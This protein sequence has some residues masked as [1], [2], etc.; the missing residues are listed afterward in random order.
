MGESLAAG[1]LDEVAAL[2]CTRTEGWAVGLQLAC[3]S[4]RA[5]PDALALARGIS[6]TSRHIA[7]FLLDEVLGHQPEALLQMLLVLALPERFCQ[8]LYTALLQEQPRGLAQTPIA[9]IERQGLFLV[10]LDDE[11]TWY[12]YHHF[13]RDLLLFRLTE[14]I[15]SEGVALLHRRCSV[16][17]ASRGLIEE[18]VRHALQVGDQAMAARLVEESYSALLERDEGLV[19][20]APLL[21]LLP[22]P[23]IA[24]RPRLLLACA[25]DCFIRWDF[26][27]FAAMT[28]R[29][30]AQLGPTNQ[31]HIFEGA[32]LRGDIALLEGIARFWVGDFIRAGALIEEAYQHISAARAHTY[33]LTVTYLGGA[34]FHCGDGGGAITFIRGHLRWADAPTST[35]TAML[36]V[37]LNYINLLSGRLD[38]VAHDARQLSGDDPNSN[39]FYWCWGQYLLG[40]YHYERNELEAAEICFLRASGFPYNAQ[41]RVHHDSLMGLAHIAL[42]RG[43]HKRA[44]SYGHRGRVFAEERANPGLLEATAALE[45]VVALAQGDWASASW[46]VQAIDPALY[47]GHALWLVQARWCWAAV[48]IGLA[49]PESL[50]E[51]TASLARYLAEAEVA[52]NVYWQIRAGGLLALAHHAQGQHEAALA[53]LGRAV[54]L[55][56]PGGHIRSLVDCGPPIAA[57]LRQLSPGN[58]GGPNVVRVLAAFGEGAQPPPERTASLEA[59]KAAGTATPGLLSK[60]EQDILVL[61]AERLTDQE[62]AER[63]IIAITTVRTHTRRIYSKLEVTNR[64]QAISRAGELGLL[65]GYR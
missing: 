34:R 3:L 32:D 19:R 36:L 64:R 62:I 33:A 23:L 54:S 9:E 55:A 21:A 11:G 14:T 52:H 39:R 31:E 38:Q 24:S 30:M 7:D 50:A 42:V 2:L 58:S 27:A 41:E 18:A 8:E 12:R 63:L 17:F 57:L 37:G 1:S 15:G 5:A 35:A 46:H 65:E 53:A 40:R 56:A 45:A 51:A 26:S 61:L 4:L 43:E 59:P 25:F 49:T 48:Q 20:L 60:R 44:A 16:W 22:E 29:V 6:G 47:T 28:G 10:A 13:V